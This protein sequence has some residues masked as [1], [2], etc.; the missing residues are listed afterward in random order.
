MSEEIKVEG[1]APEVEVKQYSETEQQAMS[2]GW[3]PKDQF[4]GDESDFRSA[5]DFIERGE[6]IGRIRSQSKQI[7]NV[8]QALRHIT[9]Q[10]TKVFANGYNQAIAALK[11]ERRQALAD[12]DLVAAE[13]IADKIESAKEEANVVVRQA[14]APAANIP[15]VDPEHQAWVDANPWYQDRVMRNFADSMAKEF[16]HA[17]QGQVTANEVRAFVAKTVKEEFQHRFT[18]VQGAP[19]PDS[20]GRGTTTKSETT[21]STS[22]VKQ[23][24]SEDEVRIMKTLMK[25]TGMT[26]K[27]YLKMYSEAR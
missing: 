13:D 19:N 12:G 14:Q 23:G 5:K 15:R 18:K 16:I 24:M 20:E 1:E 9:E 6:M 25:S 26:E 4:E 22:K 7:Q 21:V 27:E 10:N 2:L 8:E 3:K 17:N 11:A